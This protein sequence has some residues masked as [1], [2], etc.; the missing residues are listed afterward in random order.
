MVHPLIRG[1]CR[2]LRP[3]DRRPPWQWCEEHVVVDETS[4]FPGKFRTANSPWV[5]EV[6]EEAIR[7]QRTVVR[8]SAQSSK[9]QT[10]LNLACYAVSEDPG[11]AMWVMAAKDEA[12][13][14]MRDRVDPTFDRCKPVRQ[15]LNA[16][17]GMTFVF[18]TM[19][20][21]FT[22]SNSPS[23]LQSK[24][25]RWL[26][27][28]E[29]RNYPAGALQMVLKRTRAFSWCCH[30]ILLSTPDME[31][32]E[33]DSE[34][35]A[36]DQ[37][38]WHYCC[39][40]C[41]T[42]QPL[43]FERL[44]WDTNE[45]TKPDGKW[46]LDAV[47]ETIR[48]HCV[49]CPHVWRDVPEER[50]AIADKGRFMATNPNAP[51]HRVSFHWNALLPPW[52]PWRS[53]VEEFLLASQ[54]LRNDPPD[55][56]PYKTFVNETLGKSWS[57]ALGIIDDYGFLEDRKAD[58]D[59]GDVWAEEVDR[60][61]AADK[62]EKGGEH[63][64]WLIRAFGRNAKSRLIA[65]GRASTT[66]ELEQIRAQYKVPLRNAMI[67]SGY[68]A[69]EVYRFC[70]R[71]GWKPF[72]GD[73]TEFYVVSVIDPKTAQPKSVRQLW[74]KAQVDPYSGTKRGG[75]SAPISLY[76]FAGETTKDFLAEFMHGMIGD[77]TVTRQIGREYLQQVTAE[78]RTAR[79][80]A[81]GRTHYVWQQVRPDNHLLDCECM[82]LVA[83][84][85]IRLVHGGVVRV[86]AAPVDATA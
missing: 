72:K 23:K 19:P 10:I 62:Q 77:W 13:D 29:V 84:V 24:P 4:P 52:V 78:R 71:S 75:R 76:R 35:N 5:R 2:G 40:D 45:R 26:F 59:F 22:G 25:I 28:D 85:I 32:D 70:A 14:F 9:T 68:K 57:S 66:E 38:V 82:V 47:T 43:E 64:W 20:F 8:C 63:Y 37:R 54:A 1:F 21:Y 51:K 18:Q 39:P 49:A 12:R 16:K 53:V 74:S 46:N 58:Y 55:L 81:R 60:F 48:L 67:D 6:M 27:L 15:L 41:G 36:G 30:E 80:D 3:A 33:V 50:R 65:Y 7:R 34:Y 17:E 83:A 73:A 79:E 61:M 56:E 11:P 31:G 86:P 42:W 44:K 69:T